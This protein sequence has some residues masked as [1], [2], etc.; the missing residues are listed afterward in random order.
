[1]QLR[2]SDLFPRSDRV[3]LRTEYELARPS[4]ALKSSARQKPALLGQGS[5]NVTTRAAA[6]PR[7]GGTGFTAPGGLASL[8]PGN[9]RP[10][11]S[12]RVSL[13]PEQRFDP[14]LT[15]L[16]LSRRGAIKMRRAAGPLPPPRSEQVP[17]LHPGSSP[18]SPRA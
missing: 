11:V 18:G 16:L 10:P 1:M 6:G 13:Y 8:P 3:A 17:P 5:Y 14:D 9:K 4:E 7:P 12:P 2:C 15:A